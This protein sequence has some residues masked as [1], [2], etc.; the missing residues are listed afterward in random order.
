M[1]NPIINTNPTDIAVIGL[2]C[3]FPGSRNAS[4]FWDNLVAGKE[5]IQKLNKSELASLGVNKDLLDHPNYI[6]SCAFL[7]DIDKFDNEFF[8]ISSIEAAAMDPQHRLFL[9]EAYHALED[10]GYSSDKHDGKIGIYAGSGPTQYYYELIRNNYFSKHPQSR[11]LLYYLGNEKDFLAL[12]VAYSLNLTGPAIN[13]NLASA[14]GLAVVV[15]ACQSLVNGEADIMLA[16]ASSIIL[17]NQFGY[18]YEPENIFSEDGHCRPFDK[19]STGTVLGSGVGVVALKRLKDA[20]ADN[21]S[22]YA[23]IKGYAINNDGSHKI[24]FTA[25]SVDGQSACFEEALKMSRVDAN[26]LKFIEAHGTGTHLGDPIE[27]AALTKGLSSWT[28]KQKFCAIGSVKGNIGHAQSAAGIAGFIKLILSIKNRLIPPTLHFETANSKIDFKNSPFYI[29][30][31]ASNWNDDIRVGGV[32]ALAMGG[33][34]TNIIVMN[35]DERRTEDKIEHKYNIIPLSATNNLS[36]ET[37]KNNLT[38]YLNDLTLDQLND[39]NL[40]HSIAYTL[41]TGRKNLACKSAYICKNINDLLTAIKSE[42]DISIKTHGEIAGLKNIK[43]EWIS[44]ENVDWNA[45]YQDSPRRISLPHYP[46]NKVSHWLLENSVGLSQ[47]NNPVIGTHDESKPGIKAIIEIVSAIWISSLELKTISY[48]DDFQ[49]L[50][51]D[52]LLA[53]DIICEIEKQLGIKISIEDFLKH[54]SIINLAKHIAH[55]NY[56]SNSIACLKPLTKQNKENPTSFIIHPGNGELYF[57]HDLANLLVNE[58]NLIGISNNV[59]NDI[60]ENN[61]ISIVQLAERYTKLIQ[62]HQPHGPYILSGWSFGGVIA[63]EMTRQLEERG[64]S[65]DH[66]FLIDSWAKYSNKFNDPDYFFN[67]YLTNGNDDSLPLKDT[68]LWGKLL[69]KRMKALFN[70]EPTAI[71]A[72]TTLLKASSIN[73]EYQD[74]NAFDNHWQKYCKHVLSTMLIA[75]NHETILQRPGLEHLAGIITSAIDKSTVILERDK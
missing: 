46:F 73:E 74:I 15:K 39:S 61:A 58:L 4:L 32:N 64:E 13:I 12:R 30:S 72:D 34:N 50:G 11:Q 14:T 47:N 38:S 1:K 2:S 18:I 20:I 24:G 70:Y 28:D 8:K 57:Y 40:F 37:I 41:Q 7:D 49:S 51:G 16:G 26:Y 29:N 65:V 48:E 21:D 67:S 25:P 23:V 54:R 44:G 42:K 60:A 45:L 52:S 68:G 55:N 33:V 36:L 3:R 62:D 31:E 66:L 6:N 71:N 75:G 22:I 69:W 5:L 59:F 35:Y 56:S 27:I 17:P 19:D 43:D 9:E 63:F 53:I 10:A